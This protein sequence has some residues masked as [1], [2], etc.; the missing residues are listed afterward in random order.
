MT[1]AISE[2]LMREAYDAVARYRNQSAAARALGMPRQTLNTRYAI[3]LRDLG[4]PPVEISLR[5]VAVVSDAPLP[6]ADWEVRGVSQHIDASGAVKSQHVRSAPPRGEEYDMMPGHVVKGESAL[7]DAQGRVMQ[8]WVK[9][10]EGAVGAGLV[11]A[12]QAA[13]EGYRGLVAPPAAAPQGDDD[14]LTIYP[15]PDLH[16]GMLA[17][18]RESGADYDIEIAT[19]MAT[20]AMAALV[21]QSR[22]SRK[23][24][25]LG[26]GDYF[27]SNDAKQVTPGS[28]HKLDVDGRWPKVFEGGARLLVRL[29]EMVAAKHPDVEVVMLPGN[30][31]P[32]AAVSLAIAMRLLF[33]R[34]P[35]VRVHDGHGLAWYGRHGACL[36]GATHGHTMKPDRMAMMLAN[37]RPEDWGATQFRHFFFGHIHHESVKEVGAVRVESFSTPAARDAFAA[38]GGYR[39]GRALNALTFCKR[40]GEIG[41]HRVNIGHTKPRI[42]RKAA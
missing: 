25:L 24:V 15:L 8:R 2:K 9:T 11:E 39:S 12:M 18:G 27:H 22:P 10:R 14:L 40:D 3:A 1:P 38:G 37:D 32:D 7:I 5:R 13:F 20:R 6:P 16:F 21:S 31:D 36:F 23:A 33:E 19:D 30:H 26:L 17:W 29:I 35:G 42:R 28:G 41:R 4:L 34:V